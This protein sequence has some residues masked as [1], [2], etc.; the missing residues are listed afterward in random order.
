MKLIS[1]IKSLTV[2]GFLLVTAFSVGVVAQTE[3]DKETQ[4]ACNERC[5]NEEPTH[6]DSCKKYEL[7]ESSPAKN[8]NYQADLE[9]C[10]NKKVNSCKSRNKCV[11]KDNAKDRKNECN[12][13]MDKYA[14]AAKE[15]SGACESF[16]KVGGSKNSCDERIK[17]CRK[18][19]NDGV[20]P[21]SDAGNDALMKT[22]LGIYVQQ[23]FPNANAN[24][25]PIDGG[26]TG[27]SCTNY[28]SKEDRKEKKNE[29][30]DLDKDIDSL[31]DKINEEKKKIND[32]NANLLEKTA[33]NE[34]DQ[35]KVDEAV[36][37]AIR[38]VD[39]KKGERLRKLNEDLAK[40][41]IAIRKKNEEIILEKEKVERIKFENAQKMMQFTQ[42][43][44][45]TQCQTAIDTAKQCFIRSSK[46]QVT[47]DPKDPCAGLTISAKG[48]KGTAQLKAKV[49]KVKEACFEQANLTLN[50]NKFDIAATLRT[51]EMA[52]L[53]KKNEI[54]D[55]QNDIERR[56]N[57]YTSIGNNR[58]HSSC[59]FAL[60]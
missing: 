11:D 1:P 55:A 25:F 6:T 43:K 18:K 17:A 37:K 31:K 50:K 13:A 40:S 22:M 56:Q 38:S 21:D 47:N 7:I 48:A 33:E 29:L 27:P 39:E 35:Q 14:T 57:D 26:T 41:A 28:K 24:D 30:K 5:E 51:S 60:K 53:N 9:R 54:T 3:A 59:D 4:N 44:I 36:K 45:S 52:L 46:G 42:D 16:E 2:V 20:S 23:N 19:M 8:P 10:V 15:A 32:E 34:S 49:A 58:I 12:G